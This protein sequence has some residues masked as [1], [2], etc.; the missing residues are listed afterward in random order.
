VYDILLWL[1]R[2]TW[3]E[4]PVVGGRARGEQPPGKPALVTEIAPAAADAA[5]ATVTGVSQ[6]AE[7]LMMERRKGKGNDGGDG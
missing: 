4:M 1:V 7:K 5:V 3:Y 2:A 6:T